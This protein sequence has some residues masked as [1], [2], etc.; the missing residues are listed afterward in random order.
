MPRREP[1]ELHKLPPP[2]VPLAEA[3][4]E[5]AVVPQ[6]LP[7]ATHGGSLV[8]LGELAA[9]HRS[10]WGGR[11]AA[12]AGSAG[13]TTT[14]SVTSALVES[15]LPGQ[16]HS[17]RGNLNNRI[18][19]PMTLLGLTQAHKVAVIEIGTNCPGEVEALAKV[20]RPDVGVL[21]LI[22]RCC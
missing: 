13:K 18:G 21:T 4:H 9:H 10:R 12:I 3:A 22:E 6:R 14:R 15:L 2:R 19:V 5:G 1:Q 7:E 16:V 17:T 11:I 20:T 8:A